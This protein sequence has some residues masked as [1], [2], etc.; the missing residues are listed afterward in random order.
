METIENIVGFGLTF[1]GLLLH[2]VE[3]LDPAYAFGK[4]FKSIE[5]P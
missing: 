5:G 4:L 1:F 2:A 3:I